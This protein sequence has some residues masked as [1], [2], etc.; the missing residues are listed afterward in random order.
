MTNRTR[1]AA[2][3]FAVLAPFAAASPSQASATNIHDDTP[4][5]VSAHEFR[6]VARGTMSEVERSLGVVGHG[7]VV[8]S[9]GH[10]QH[11]IRQYPYGGRHQCTHSA[12][13]IT[14]DLN[15]DGRYM[16]DAVVLFIYQADRMSK[17]SCAPATQH[18]RVSPVR[19]IPL[20]G[21]M[22]QS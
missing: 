15:A 22:P 8:W 12:A 17:A 5:Y 19:V 11:V 14:Y 3:A 13:Q 9:A 4:G 16:A 10:G 2:V 7:R 20:P 1:T 21:S 18:P 6:T